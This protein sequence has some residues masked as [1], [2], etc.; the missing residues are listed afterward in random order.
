MKDWIGLPL[1]RCRPMAAAEWEA[2]IAREKRRDNRRAQKN[3]KSRIRR[4]DVGAHHGQ[5]PPIPR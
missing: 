3:P 2:L 5:Q 1:E 4:D